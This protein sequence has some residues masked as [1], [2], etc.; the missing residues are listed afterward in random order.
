MLQILFW[1]YIVGCVCGVI[2][3]IL[4]S[5][6]I[7]GYCKR[8]GLKIPKKHALEEFC[9]TLKIIIM[10]ILPVYHYILFI[11]TLFYDNNKIETM[12]RNKISDE[13]QKNI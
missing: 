2:S 7:S 8:A 9:A 1:I 13:N 5:L 10:C 6:K 12:V 11:G 4:I 3:F